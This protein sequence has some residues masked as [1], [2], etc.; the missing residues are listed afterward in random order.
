M[1]AKQKDG[2]M[3][4]VAFLRAINV[5][6]HVV[7]MEVLKRQFAKMGFAGVETFIASGN[8]VFE[9]RSKSREAAERNIEHALHKALGYEVVRLTWADLDH[10]RRVDALVRSALARASN[11]RVELT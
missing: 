7:T 5:G 4:H 6:G 11:R 1:T 8:V 2:G 3:R 10:P 9:T